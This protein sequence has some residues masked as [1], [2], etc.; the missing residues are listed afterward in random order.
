M[1]YVNMIDLLKG[2]FQWLLYTGVKF[3][4]TWLICS[5]NTC[6]SLGVTLTAERTFLCAIKMIVILCRLLYSF[7]TI[8]CSFLGFLRIFVFYCISKP[9][10]LCPL[11]RTFQRSIQEFISQKQ[12]ILGK[13]YRLFNCH[14]CPTKI[15]VFIKTGNW[16]DNLYRK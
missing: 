8:L 11:K 10:S 4:L 2:W 6:N 3:N 7:A 12:N 1:T 9:T 15:N 5:K 13:F 14:I 16:P